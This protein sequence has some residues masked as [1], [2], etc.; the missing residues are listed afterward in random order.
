MLFL[1]VFYANNWLFQYVD[2]RH[3]SMLLIILEEQDKEEQR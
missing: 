1:L 3:Q 2:S